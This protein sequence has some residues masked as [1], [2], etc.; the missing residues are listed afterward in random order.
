MDKSHFP[1][2][3]KMSRLKLS[4]DKKISSARNSSWPKIS[5]V[6]PSYN[7]GEFI[8]DTILSVKNQ[9][10][11]DFEHII[12]DGGS[13]DAT[14]EILKKYE[15]TYNMHWTSEPDKGQS[16]AVN[17]GFRTA[18]GQIIGWLNS[19]DVYFSTDV[20]A[21]VA[22]EFLENPNV[23]VIYANRVV[24]DGSNNLVKLQ[25]SRKF[26]Y[27]KLLKSYYALHQET[28]FL[29]KK[30][31]KQQQLN[32]DLY[33]TMDSEFWLRLGS[34]FHFKYVNAFFGGFR[35]HKINKTVVDDNVSKWNKEKQYLID[36][37]RARRY[38]IGGKF[39][40]R[41]LLNQVKAAFSGGYITYY[42]LPLDVISLSF[43][44]KKNLAFPLKVNR[45]KYINYLLCSIVPYMK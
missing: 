3:N 39:P 8:E 25:Y 29:R 2:K 41:R 18:K 21:R 35:V 22:A 36:K 20:F 15:H 11:P 12:V 23:D 43:S 24:I 27:N 33:I 16:D 32:T 34:L 31:V 28:V 38:M 14:L 37:Y 9:I 10:Y 4:P 17:K 26:N 6:T 30:V 19:D 40:W 13:T 5:I 7:Q 45:K 44:R 42:K 1:G